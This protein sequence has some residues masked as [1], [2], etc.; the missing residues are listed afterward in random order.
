LSPVLGRQYAGGEMP[1]DEF[2]Q[3]IVDPREYRSEFRIATVAFG[4]P[5]PFLALDL[6]RGSPDW[7]APSG[8]LALFVVAFVQAR[9]FSRLHIKHFRNAKAAIKG[10]TIQGLSDSYKNLERQLFWAGLYGTAVWAYG[11]KLIKVLVR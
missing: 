11:D 2:P 9:Q 6:W 7:F 10:E 1:T 5:I 8:A 4:I 3:P